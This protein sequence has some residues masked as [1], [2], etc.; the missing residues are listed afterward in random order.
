MDLVPFRP[1]HLAGIEPQALPPDLLA[2][3]RRHYRPLGPAWTGIASRRIV[4][5]GG[6]VVAGEVG[7]A[8]AILSQ[9]VPVAAVHRA[10]LRLLHEAYA[11]EGLQRIEASAFAAW[12]G[13]CRWLERLG[14][15]RGGIEGEY[16]RYKL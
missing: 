12:P 8:W 5:C 4:G 7:W 16:R 11:A 1:E 2:Y 13:A 6:I 15:Q 9:P 10:A 3:F 14:F